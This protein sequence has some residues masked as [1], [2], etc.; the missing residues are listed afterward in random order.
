MSDDSRPIRLLRHHLA[1]IDTRSSDIS[2]KS[3]KLRES[4]AAIAGDGP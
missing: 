1:D 2:R 3:P 4:L